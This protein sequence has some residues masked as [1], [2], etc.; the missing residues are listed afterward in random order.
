MDHD[1]RVA[2]GA[3]LRRPGRNGTRGGTAVAR[4][5][6]ACRDGQ[7]QSGG[8]RGGDEPRRAERAHERDADRIAGWVRLVAC[9]GRTREARARS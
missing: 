4:V 2:A 7:R 6:Q 9:A 1:H 3:L 5:R 8:R